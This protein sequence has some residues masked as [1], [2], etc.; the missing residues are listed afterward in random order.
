M[1]VAYKDCTICCLC[2]ERLLLRGPST[3]DV[4]GKVAISELGAW[5]K[6]SGPTLSSKSCVSSSPSSLSLLAK[7]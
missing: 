5:C 4:I 3:G 7:R 2:G 6:G 1:W